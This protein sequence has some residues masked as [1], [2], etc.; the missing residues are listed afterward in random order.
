MIRN[1]NVAGSAIKGDLKFAMI[2]AKDVAAVATEHLTKMDFVDK[3]VRDLLGQRDLSLSEAISVIGKRINRPDLR[4]V[5]FSYKDA[6]KGLLGA[7]LSENM[8]DLLIEMSKAFNEGLFG[9]KAPRTAE[10]TT[11]TSIEEFADTFAEI[12]FS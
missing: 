7:G 5:Q 6:K 11:A 10:N 3:S 2:A 1:M 8:A 4:Y 12:F 9:V